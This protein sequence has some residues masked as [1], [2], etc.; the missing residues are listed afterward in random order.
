MAHIT[1]IDFVGGFGTVQWVEVPEYRRASPDRIVTRSGRDSPESTLAALNAA[2]GAQL[3]RLLAAPGRGGAAGAPAP[4]AAARGA[5]APAH[6]GP[7]DEA[8]L[9]SIDRAGVDVRVRRGGAMAVERLRFP[10]PVDT[11]EEAAGE[12]RAMLAAAEALM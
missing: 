12:M 4:A 1:D 7:P 2:F 6:A 8:L 11:P 10:A 3:P 5:A 9:V